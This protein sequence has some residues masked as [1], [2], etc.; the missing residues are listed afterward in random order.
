MSDMSAVALVVV[1]VLS[2]ALGVVGAA[3]VRRL[4]A[5]TI[6]LVSG[7]ALALWIAGNRGAPMPISLGLVI[8]GYAWG[9]IVAK[10]VWAR[11]GPEGPENAARAHESAPTHDS[12]R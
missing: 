7:L 6:G 10:L 11:N 5:L 9:R 2:I 3:L 1:S 4:S 8:L 12:E